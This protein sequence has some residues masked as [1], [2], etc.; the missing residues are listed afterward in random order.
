MVCFAAAEYKRIFIVQSSDD[1]NYP[2][3]IIES[4][5]GSSYDES[6]YNASFK[7]FAN[8]V[9]WETKLIIK[10][11]TLEITS[12]QKGRGSSQNNR[13]KFGGGIEC[14]ILNEDFYKLLEEKGN[15]LANKLKEEADQ[16]EQERKDKIE[17]NRSNNQI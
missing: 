16:R 8:M 4:Y 3:Q 9:V 7:Y 6:E 17:K 1:Y 15:K 2:L 5:L 13:G 11:D 12:E 10:R 14:K